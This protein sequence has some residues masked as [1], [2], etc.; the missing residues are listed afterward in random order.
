MFDFTIKI[1][2]AVFLWKIVNGLDINLIQNM[3]LS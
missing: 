3:L 2:I 1:L